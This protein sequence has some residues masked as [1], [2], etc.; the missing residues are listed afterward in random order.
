MNYP[1]KKVAKYFGLYGTLISS[2]PLLVGIIVFLLQDPFYTAI[3]PTEN[4]FTDKQFPKE[5][6]GYSWFLS[7]IGE[8]GFISVMLYCFIF[9]AKKENSKILLFL[10]LIS[11]SAVYFIAASIEQY[12]YNKPMELGI[13]NVY[14]LLLFHFAIPIGIYSLVIRA[15]IKRALP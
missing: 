15:F 14:M 10:P 13:L 8:L 3:I 12:I 2:L 11:N 9:K 4:G 5:L 6:N 1:Y 7:L